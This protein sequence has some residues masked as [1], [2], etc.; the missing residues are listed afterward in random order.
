MFIGYAKDHEGDCYQMYNPKTDDV[1]TTRDVIWLRRMFY[2]A[3]TTGPELDDD[4]VIT[5]DDIVIV[6]P[7]DNKADKNQGKSA[8]ESVDDADLADDADDDE[9]MPRL[10]QHDAN[11]SDS[12]DEVQRRRMTKIRNPKKGLLLAGRLQAEPCERRSGTDTK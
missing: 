12:S 6:T 5:N 7:P 1:H 8:G 10:L 11:D 2:T 9:P 3:P 4:I